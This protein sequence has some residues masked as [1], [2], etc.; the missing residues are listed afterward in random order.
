MDRTRIGMVV[1]GVAAAFALALAA[2]FLIVEPRGAELMCGALDAPGW[3]PLRKALV[4]VFTFQGFGAASL[5][6]GA[7]AV[8]R[9]SGAA[10]VAA[11][12]F[13][14]AG[15]VLYNVEMG[16][17]GTLL[18]LIALTRAPRLSA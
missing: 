1:L 15:M 17:V 4:P 7:F 8:W 14:A 9:W 11:L 6:A 3:C 16:S 2:R 18:G 5:L 10:G 13:G 12:V